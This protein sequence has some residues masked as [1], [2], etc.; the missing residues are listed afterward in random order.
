MHSISVAAT[1][2][3]R[4]LRRSGKCHLCGIGVVFANINNGQIPNSRKIHA[5]V[6]RP[7]IHRSIAE[8]ADGHLSAPAKLRA[9]SCSCCERK[10]TTDN[11]VCT[12]EAV[13]GRIHVHASPSTPGTARR[14]A[15]EL[16]HDFTPRY[17]LSKGM[18]M[19]AVSTEYEVFFLQMRRNSNRDGFLSDI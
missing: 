15:P 18:S 10:P 2:D 12:H 6:K 11:S 1:G 7:T 4:I 14:L 13:F 3:T 16:S 17:S 9:E 19:S 5:L 8:I